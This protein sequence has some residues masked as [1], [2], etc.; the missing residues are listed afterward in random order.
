MKKFFSLFLS[1]LLLCTLVA[2]S[3]N[4]G[5]EYT[6]S[7]GTALSE[8]IESLTLSGTCAAVVTDRDGRIVLCRLDSAE[9]EARIEGTGVAH[10]TV[11][12][13]KYE[14]GDSYGMK[15]NGGA[16]A[17]WYEQARYFESFAK[18][19]TLEEISSVKTGES[20]L[21]GG[22]TIDVTDF[23]RAIAAAM[24]S[25]KGV[26]FSAEGD[27]SAGLAIVAS[28]RDS[29][30]NAEFLYDS[31]A[32]VVADGKVAAALTDSSESTLTLKDGKGESFVYGGTKSELGEDY[33]MVEH[34]GALA[35]WYIQARNY[36]SAAKGKS[37]EELST[38]PV[39]NVSGCTIDAEPLK[40]A[41][42][43]AGKNVR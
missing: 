35:E 38:L 29:K 31:A 24:K 14:M 42:V 40:E 17:E 2:C 27:M 32:T 11:E 34:G 43:R 13:T 4:S 3:D 18:G 16:I 20:D 33:G 25:D 5:G 12:H 8:D 23:V 21:S 1:A 7:L 37:P 41:L 28:V 19:K 22:C 36:A 30:G 15:Q 39:D 10:T 6:L 9:A 26:S